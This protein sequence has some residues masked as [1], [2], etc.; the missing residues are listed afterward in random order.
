MP[1]YKRPEDRASETITIRLTLKE[2]RMLGYLAHLEGKTLTDFIK[3]LIADRATALEVT[4]APE[5]PLGKRP[6]KAKRSPASGAAR[7]STPPVPS[8][9]APP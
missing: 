6:G 7:H 4:E 8:P 2:R 3:G 5:L 9:P 1:L